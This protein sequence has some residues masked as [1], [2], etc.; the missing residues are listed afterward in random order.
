ME[1][2][3]YCGAKK[4]YPTKFEIRY[5][6]KYEYPTT[7]TCGTATSPN[8]GNPVRGKRCIENESNRPLTK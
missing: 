8:W 4:K 3:P 2:C 5:G 6:A 1:N 7:Y